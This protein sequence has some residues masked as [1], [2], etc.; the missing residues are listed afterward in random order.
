MWWSCL[1]Y[2]SDPDHVAEAESLGL[3]V[4]YM[5]GDAYLEFLKAQ[6]AD[7]IALKPELGWE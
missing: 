3:M 7:V 1:L 4:Q 6:E 5:D 2:T